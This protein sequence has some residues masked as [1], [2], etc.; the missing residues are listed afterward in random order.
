M[1]VTISRRS[2]GQAGQEFN[3][4]SGQKGVGLGTFADLLK[5]KR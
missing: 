3:A 4:S 1:S 5:A 2:L